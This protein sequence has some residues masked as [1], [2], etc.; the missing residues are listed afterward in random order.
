[1]IFILQNRKDTNLTIKGLAWLGIL[2]SDLLGLQLPSEALQSLTPA[3][4]GKLAQLA[5]HPQISK[6]PDWCKEVDFLKLKLLFLFIEAY[7]LPL[8]KL[9]LT[10]R[11]LTRAYTV[12]MN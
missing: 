2:P 8:K 12:P 1:M 11:T 6:S 7:E 3:D 10:R 4:H 9:P 5:V